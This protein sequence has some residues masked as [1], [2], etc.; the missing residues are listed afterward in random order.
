MIALLDT[1]VLIDVA[2]GRKPFN[3]YSAKVLDYA[4]NHKFQAFIA[5]HSIANFYYLV[6]STSN[7]KQ[8]RNFLHDLLQFVNI[9]Q[10]STDDARNALLLKVSD[11]EDALQIAA[12][13][14]CN[15]AVIVTRN[16]KHYRRS[17]IPAK[18]PER[19]ISTEF[20]NPLSS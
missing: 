12:A 18:S 6:A 11:F 8:T 5:W 16:I 13:R 9:S 2:I 7:I 15:A 17:P 4:E 10:T 14:A 3:K 20:T 1:D 19:F